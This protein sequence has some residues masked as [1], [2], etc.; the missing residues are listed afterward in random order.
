MTYSDN[1]KFLETNKPKF[2]TKDLWFLF[3]WLTQPIRG[4]AIVALWLIIYLYQGG[5]RNWIKDIVIEYY[6]RAV[7]NDVIVCISVI[8]YFIHKQK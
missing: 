6:I 5:I 7:Y 3:K 4:I 8:D 2:Q 1:M